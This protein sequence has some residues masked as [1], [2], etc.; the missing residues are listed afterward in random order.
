M[1]RATA[2]SLWR[3]KQARVD[4]VKKQAT[5]HDVDQSVWSF[6]GKEVLQHYQF[7]NSKTSIVVLFKA[8]YRDFNDAGIQTCYVDLLGPQ[9]NQRKTIISNTFHCGIYPSPNQ[10]HAALRYINDKGAEFIMIINKNGET[11]A[12]INAEKK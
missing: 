3:G 10:E 1:G 8:S 5:L 2:V 7:P 4:T 12:E 11:V 6:E 9:P